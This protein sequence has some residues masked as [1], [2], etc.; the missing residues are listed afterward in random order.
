MMTSDVMTL[1]HG[2][3]SIRL[4][5]ISLVLTSHGCL[6]R[7]STT[8]NILMGDER[9]RNWSNVVLIV[10]TLS[11]VK[12]L[13]LLNQVVLNPT[14]TKKRSKLTSKLVQSSM[15]ICHKKIGSIGSS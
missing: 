12:L 4:Q 14:G 8:S 10:G 2:D 11:F 1:T 9:S 3:S 6:I 7:S 13:H 5:I 15:G